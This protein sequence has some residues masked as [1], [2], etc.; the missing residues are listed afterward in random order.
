MPFLTVRINDRPHCRQTF[1]LS[2]LGRGCPFECS[3]CTIINVQGRK[4]RCPH[5]PTMVEKHC[6]L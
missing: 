5:G 3:F 1:E 4:S 2:T 6:P